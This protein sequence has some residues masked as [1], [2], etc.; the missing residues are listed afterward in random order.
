MDVK[1]AR[2]RRTAYRD[3]VL[4][5][6]V[7]VKTDHPGTPVVLAYFRAAQRGDY[8]LAALVGNDADRDIDWYD[9]NLHQAFVDLDDNWLLASGPGSGV[10]REAF[11]RR[12]LAIGS[13]REDLDREL[14]D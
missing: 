11:A 10:D 13:V 3:G 2:F 5:G 1:D 14:T 12:V 7:E 9:N 4:C 6:E 8:E